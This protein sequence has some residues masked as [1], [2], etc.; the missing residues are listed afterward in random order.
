MFHFI[1]KQ[2]TKIRK[3]PALRPSS[4]LIVDM[5]RWKHIV[6][7]AWKCLKSNRKTWSCWGSLSC[8]CIK[9][10]LSSSLQQNKG[11]EERKEAKRMKRAWSSRRTAEKGVASGRGQRPRVSALQTKQRG[12]CAHSKACELVRGWCAE[13]TQ[14]ENITQKSTICQ[15]YQYDV[16]GVKSPPLSSQQTMDLCPST[17]TP[18]HNSLQ[19]LLRDS[20][21]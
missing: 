9:F 1:R 20:L 14:P 5:L 3:K 16:L 17:A 10:T 8:E 21:L 15:P 2:T 13:H 11:A 4:L 12:P 18:A 7:E 6:N 19:L